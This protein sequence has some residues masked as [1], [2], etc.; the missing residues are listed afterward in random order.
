MDEWEEPEGTVK[1]RR[2]IRG[3]SSQRLPG[4]RVHAHRRIRADPAR[5][6][7]PA[8]HGRTGATV[9]AATHVAGPELYRG[10]GFEG[11]RQEASMSDVDGAVGTRR[12]ALAD[13]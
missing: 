8:V 5:K 10:A 6:D 12:S 1:R 4:C 2:I 7:A 9:A 11:S 3:E 13:F